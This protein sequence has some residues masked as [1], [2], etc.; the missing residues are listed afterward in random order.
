MA[1]LRHIYVV[2]APSG[3]GKTTLNRR[4]VAE[5]PCVEISVS[6]TTRQKRDGETEGVHYHYVS[7]DEFQRQIDDGQ[8]L[9]FADVHGNFYGTSKEELQKIAARGHDAILEIDVQGWLNARDDLKRVTSIFIMPPSVEILWERLAARG[10]DSE[11]DLKKRLKNA[12]NEISLAD[13]Y[14]HFIVNDDL[15]HS[16]R[17]LTNIIIDNSTSNLSPEEG[18]AHKKKLLDEFEAS[19]IIKKIS[20][21]A[22]K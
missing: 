9:E 18:L 13:K 6:L 15:E 22:D 10:T 16:Y 14:D 7:K 20:G 5:H 12:K 3:A 8:M 17:Q 21:N 2:S 19:D 11:K 1:R 4:L